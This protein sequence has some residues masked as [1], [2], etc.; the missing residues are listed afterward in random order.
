MRAQIEEISRD[1]WLVLVYVHTQQKSVRTHAPYR[2]AGLYLIYDM[3]YAH[4]T[5]YMYAQ[6]LGSHQNDP[7]T[8]KMRLIWLVYDIQGLHMACH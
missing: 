2:D 4:S 3:I 8:P 6:I 1:Q 5:P 7:K